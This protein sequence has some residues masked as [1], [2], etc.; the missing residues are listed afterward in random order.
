MQAYRAG[1]CREGVRGG[2]EDQWLVGRRLYVVY[3]A[4]DKV[5]AAAF[6]MRDIIKIK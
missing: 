1:Y 2:R 6:M 3:S 4:F 5:S